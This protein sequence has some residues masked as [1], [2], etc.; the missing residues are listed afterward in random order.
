[1]RTILKQR[2]CICAYIELLFARLLAFFSHV[3]C[4]VL[5]FSVALIM[6][7]ATTCQKYVYAVALTLAFI[8]DIMVNENDLKW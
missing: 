6:R 4:S 3:P 7:C 5:F 1:M 8:V 2:N